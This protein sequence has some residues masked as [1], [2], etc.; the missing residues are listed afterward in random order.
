M[1]EEEREGLTEFRR[2]ASLQQRHSLAVRFAAY[3]ARH[4]AGVP[5]EDKDPAEYVREAEQASTG[6]ASTGQAST[7]QARGTDSPGPAD[8]S[9]GIGRLSG[10]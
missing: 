6:Q 3:E 5:P 2:L 4:W 9:L 8:G 1:A 10:R 7:G